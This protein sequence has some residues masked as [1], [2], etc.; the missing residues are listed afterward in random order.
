MSENCVRILL[1]KLLGLYDTFLTFKTATFEG[2]IL[3]KKAQFCLLA[4]SKLLALQT[5]LKRWK[6]K[7]APIYFICFIV[8]NSSLKSG[9][10]SAHYHMKNSKCSLVKLLYCLVQQWNCN[11]RLVHLPWRQT[12][13]PWGSRISRA[14]PQKR[15]RIKNL[16]W[17]S[18]DHNE[19][20]PVP[21]L[22]PHQILLHTRRWKP[23]QTSQYLSKRTKDEKKKVRNVNNIKHYLWNSVTRGF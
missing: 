1:L 3:A 22:N 7:Q 21:T 11:C 5:Y 8:T 16:T 23:G 19:T 10:Q 4:F 13:G 6:N 14:T 17:T 9:E 20:T 12:S 2:Y 18:H 15:E